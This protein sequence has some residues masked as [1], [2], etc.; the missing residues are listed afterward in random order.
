[1]DAN[2]KNLTAEDFAQ[3]HIA[4]HWDGGIAQR[5]ASPYASDKQP[6]T[7]YKSYGFHCT[8]D[9]EM[10]KGGWAIVTQAPTTPEAALAHFVSLLHE[11]ENGAIPADTPCV[12]VFPNDHVEVYPKGVNSP[13]DAPGSTAR[14]LMFHPA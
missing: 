12:L 3:A 13:M 5:V 1:M 6:W 9:E 7:V 14:R 11:P 8:T 10:A 4:I 2:K